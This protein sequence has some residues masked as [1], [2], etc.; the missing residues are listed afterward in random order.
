MHPILVLSRVNDTET[1]AFV[2][3][4]SYHELKY[5]RI[6]QE[7]VIEDFALDFL[8][9]I[10]WLKVNKLQL[11]IDLNKV[12][13][14]F[15]RGE[16]L[17]QKVNLSAKSDVETYLKNNYARDWRIV[18][19]A[20]EYMLSQN[21]L[22]IGSPH[23]ERN[24]NKIV[25]LVKAVECGFLVPKSILCTSSFDLDCFFEN[26]DK[27]FKHHGKRAHIVN[28]E[29]AISS[30]NTRSFNR[31]IKDSSIPLKFGATFF[32]QNMEKHFEAKVLFV[33]G[34]IIPLGIFSQ[35]NKGECALDYRVKMS[36][37]FL[38][39]GNIHLP[40]EIDRQIRIYVAD[41]GLNICV[42]DFIID[43]DG[44]FTF[45]EVNPMG[46]FHW[47]YKITNI[48]PYEIIIKKIKNER[49]EKQKQEICLTP[50]SAN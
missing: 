40:E 10:M 27:I 5:T 50:Q 7:D 45:L 28:K 8:G 2:T 14:V 15:W 23:H 18:V 35:F 26:K 46:R 39:L 22:F 20:V 47:I 49:S 31:E 16:G 34:E 44:N 3:H 6:N 32:Q 11:K 4:L 30:S 21:A 13:V 9:R 36:E 1:N 33:C 29:L 19:E 41:L 24:G 12:E 43:E 48:N 17:N 25:D 38:R 37:E 42:I